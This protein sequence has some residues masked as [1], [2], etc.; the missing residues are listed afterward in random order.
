MPQMRGGVAVGRH[1]K[2]VISLQTCNI[3]SDMLDLLILAWRIAELGEVVRDPE[4]GQ[5]HHKIGR[6]SPLPPFGPRWCAYRAS[7]CRCAPTVGAPAS[8]LTPHLS[9]AARAG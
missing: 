2:N 4:L 5:Y 1:D 8:C 7:R 3:A 9:D 6:R